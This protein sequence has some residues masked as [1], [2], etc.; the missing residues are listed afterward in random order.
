MNTKALQDDV[1]EII[2]EIDNE[3]KLLQLKHYVSDLKERDIVLS[4]EVIDELEAM[5]N[6]F[7][8]HPETF[9]GLDEFIAQLE[10][11]KK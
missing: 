10:S 4:K 7:K 11:K 9:I 8:E 1:I 5:D 2:R 3:D 6:E